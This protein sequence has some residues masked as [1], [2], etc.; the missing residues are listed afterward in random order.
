[1]YD[2]IVPGTFPEHL[3]VRNQL[4]AYA[5]ASAGKQKPETIKP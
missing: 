1:M 4:P 3:W 5:K 2:R